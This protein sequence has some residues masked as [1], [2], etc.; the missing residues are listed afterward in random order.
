MEGLGGPGLAALAVVGASWSLLG[1]AMLRGSRALSRWCVLLAGLG[2]LAAVVATAAGAGG[3]GDLLLVSSAAVLAP[4][5][6]ATFPVLRWHHPADQL[7]LVVLL[8]CGVVPLLEL[9]ARGSAVTAELGLG[10]A[11][12][13]VAHTWWRLEVTAGRE[14]RTL[15]WAALGTAVVLLAVGLLAFLLDGAPAATTAAIALLAVLPVPM[16]VGAAL[17]DIVDVRA[18]VVRVV[19]TLV[20]ALTYVAA[21]VAVA[22]GLELVAGRTLQVGVVA[23]AGAVVAFGVGPLTRVLRASVDELL[24]GRRPD[25]LDAATALVGGIGSD[26]ARALE[27]VRT[28]LVLPYAGLRD[29]TRELASSGERPPYTRVYRLED[30]AEE[31]GGT[32]LVIGLR[33]G[34]LGPT[35]EDERVLRLVVPLLAQ[36]VR[37]TALADRLAESRGAVV[38]A[39][40]E[41]RRR[42]RRDLHDGLGPRLSGVAFTADAARNVVVGDPA[43]AQELLATLRAE[44]VTAIEEIRQLVYDM[45]PPALDELG[46]VPALRQ[47]AAGLCTAGGAPVRV[48]FQVGEPVSDL[49]AAVEVAAYRIVVEALANVARHTTSATA[50]VRVLAERDGLHLCV[51]DAG[52]PGGAWSPGVG[53]SSMWERAAEVGGSVS[54][55]PTPHGGRVLAVLPL[56]T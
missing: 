14:R 6:L 33:A 39:L 26:P 4:L 45:R 3:V 8:G 9:L 7:A 22:S 28:A 54:A 20:V 40:A 56:V 42:L 37:A 25:P 13:L 50:S 48:D 23:V 18:L 34:D 55:G 36:T 24:F 35:H 2:C 30:D 1:A 12:T 11:V 15:Q 10:S 53:L 32:E 5:S 43:R 17:P 38:A 16:Y 21:F 47:R 41:E 27:V 46:L 31:G 52:G 44:T 29:G 51:E 19:V 49:P